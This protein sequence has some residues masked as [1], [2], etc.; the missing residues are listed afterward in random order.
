MCFDLRF[1]STKQLHF[2][3]RRFQMLTKLYFL[4]CTRRKKNMNYVATSCKFMF[5]CFRVATIFRLRQFLLM[6]THSWSIATFSQI[7]N[8]L[9]R[10]K[11]LSPSTVIITVTV[12]I[13]HE[14]L[15]LLPKSAVNFLIDERHASNK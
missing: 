10:V 6:K 4:R 9:I 1:H 8:I 15:L 5:Q 7:E 3:V 11:Y 2:Y 14:I 13:F 12:C